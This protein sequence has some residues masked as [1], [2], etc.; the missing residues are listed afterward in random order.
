MKRQCTSLSFPPAESF[1]VVILGLVLCLGA[2]IRLAHA[3]GVEGSLNAFFDDLGYHTNVTHP[4]AFKGQSAHHYQGGSLYVRTSIQNAQL[5]AVTLPAISAGCGGIDAF[6]GGFS[7][8]NSDQLVQFGKAVVANAKPFAVDLAL[9]T[10]APQIKQIRDNL[11]S[12]ADRWLNQ[13]INS[14]ET[15]QA[16]LGGLAAFTGPQVKRH[17]CATMGTQNNAFADWVAAQHECGVGGQAQAQ[18]E[19]ARHDPALQDVA[20]VAHN[21][22]WSGIMKN[23]FLADDPGLGEFLMSLTGTQ[24]YGE[25][26]APHYYPSLLTDNNNL[27]QALLEG[28]DVDVY[29]CDETEACLTPDKTTATLDEVSGLQSRI[30]AT[31]EALYHALLN[32]QSLT[33]EQKAFLEYTE[34]PVL[35]VFKSA[36]VADRHP[37]LSAYSRVIAIELLNRYLKGMLNTVQGSMVNT[38]LDPTDTDRILRDIDRARTFTDGLNDDAITQ[39][40]QQQKLIERHQANDKDYRKRL[41][42]RLQQN[43]T[44]GE[45]LS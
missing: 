36:A 29:R 33:P 9:Q 13:S 27:I 38:T 43:L 26:G 11:Q 14:C 28:G 18:L 24:I 8:I 16:A 6:M 1:T 19:L 39:I 15:A 21:L 25:T 20:R 10:W 4:V 37:N 22:V 40:L 2:P 5:A 41:S 30:R 42:D 17:V 23:A 12:I 35:S 45:N 3:K 44:F 7:H 34:T 31:L 32:D